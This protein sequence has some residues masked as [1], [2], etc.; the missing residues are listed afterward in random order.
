MPY[1]SSVLNLVK[2]QSLLASYL[3]QGVCKDPTQFFIQPR[4][5]T[6]L[7]RYIQRWKGF[8]TWKL[9]AHALCA[10]LILKHCFMINV[11]SQNVV[12]DLCVI[13]SHWCCFYTRLLT[14]CFYYSEHT[15]SLKF[16]AMCYPWHPFRDQLKR[17][18][19]RFALVT[20]F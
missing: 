8:L 17:T 6:V 19:I 11:I 5:M 20:V 14:M 9:K 13:G 4:N 18:R 15:M 16:Q 7:A 10:W 2:N 3:S 12:K 1:T